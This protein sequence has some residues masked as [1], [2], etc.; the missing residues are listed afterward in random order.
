MNALTD[1]A[2]KAPV[3][4]LTDTFNGTRLSRHRSI[5][6]AVAAKHKRA[7][8]VRSMPSGPHGRPYLPTTIMRERG[9]W[10]AADDAEMLRVLSV[11]G[12]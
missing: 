8:L 7:R 11:L 9:P 5:R 4:I 1:T 10:T 3:Y 2:E 12:C 6:A